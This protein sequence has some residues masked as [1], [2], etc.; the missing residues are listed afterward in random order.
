MIEVPE[1]IAVEDFL[2]PHLESYNW[3]DLS[4]LYTALH[5]AIF[6]HQRRLRRDGRKFIT[7]PLA[8]AHFCMKIGL[9]ING[10]SAALLHDVIEEESVDIEMLRRQLR[11]YG[12]PIVNMISA[13]TRGKD[14]TAH[15]YFANIIQYAHY[16]WQ[17]VFV[18]A[19][20]RLHNTIC[21]YNGNRDKELAKL[22]ETITDFRIMCVSAK[23]LIPSTFSETFQEICE[24]IFT[25]AIQRIEV[26]SS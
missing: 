5:T 2:V 18:K 24:T 14:Q 23:H 22:N 12:D 1:T 15:E 13:L 10:I 8:V 25:K 16:D 26:L 3:E 19:V 7:H 17:I 4:I 6:Q 21:P 11:N 9:D 20:D